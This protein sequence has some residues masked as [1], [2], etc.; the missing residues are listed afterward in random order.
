MAI[1]EVAAD[2][3]LRPTRS[4]AGGGRVGSIISL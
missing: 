1:E 2:V 4:V 3:P